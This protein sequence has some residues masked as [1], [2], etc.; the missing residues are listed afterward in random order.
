MEVSLFVPPA[1]NGYEDVN[2]ESEREDPKPGPFPSPRQGQTG[3]AQQPLPGDS[4]MSITY[5][6]FMDLPTD[7]IDPVG[8][9]CN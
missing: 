5:H 7:A 3:P 2:A 4:L 1:G 6:F 8:G 9:G